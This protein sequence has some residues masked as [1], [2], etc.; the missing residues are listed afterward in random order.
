MCRELG[1]DLVDAGK[2]VDAVL[3]VV[4]D[5]ERRLHRDAAAVPGLFVRVGAGP[6]GIGLDDLAPRLG[7][8]A[9]AENVR[10]ITGAA[11]AVA[12]PA[13][14]VA[15]GDRGESADAIREVAGQPHRHVAAGG[16]PGDIDLGARAG[17]APGRN[18]ARQQFVHEGQVL[19]LIHI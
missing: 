18:H 16:M 14:G 3:G 15:A 5:L 6:A 8:E 9:R 1:P 12:I 17:R 4:E 13:V 10:A 7:V 2:V 19:S 11:G